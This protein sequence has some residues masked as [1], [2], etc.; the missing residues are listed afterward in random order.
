M[1]WAVLA[2]G[3]VTAASQP[4]ALLGDVREA[5]EAWTEKRPWRK[6]LS[7]PVL[8]CDT[9]LAS[10]WGSAVY[11]SYWM[12]LQPKLTWLQLLHMW[13]LFVL[14]VATGNY[15]LWTLLGTLRALSIVLQQCQL[16]LNYAVASATSSWVRSQRTTPGSE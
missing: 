5:M 13:P 3:G 6:Y 16:W 10:V 7:K 9:C 14:C 15:V 12:T 11:W 1:L 2:C 4:K 8:L